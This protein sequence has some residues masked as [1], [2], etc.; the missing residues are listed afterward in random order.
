[1][2][3]RPKTTQLSM[4][5]AVLEGHEGALRTVLAA[6]PR[7]HESPFAKVDGTHNGRWV[8]VNTAAEPSAPLR[9]GGLEAPMLMCSA[10]ID[11]PPREWLHDLV[12]VLGPTADAIWSHCAGWPD[13]ADAGAQ[14]DFLLDHRTTASLDFATWDV[15]V[16]EIRASLTL[17]DRVAAFAVRTQQLGADE[18]LAAYR[19]EFGRDAGGRRPHAVEEPS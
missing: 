3:R 13:G 8:V 12:Q 2:R 17:R 18:L 15:P 11:R 10:V 14:V 1:V 9:V 4:L 16:E 6:L 7:H 19:L 5:T